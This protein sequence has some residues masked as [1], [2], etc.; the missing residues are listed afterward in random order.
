MYDC[1]ETPRIEKCIICPS[2]CECKAESEAFNTEDFEEYR[3]K[4]MITMSNRRK[5]SFID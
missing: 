2:H 4:Y 5:Y 3:N 1:Y